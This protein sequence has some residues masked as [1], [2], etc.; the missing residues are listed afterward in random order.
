MEFTQAMDDFIMYIQ[1]EIN[2]SDNTI[3]AYM[4]DLNCYQDFLNQ[5]DRSTKLDNLTPSTSSRFVQDQ[6]LNRDIKPRTRR[7][8]FRIS[9]TNLPNP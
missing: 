3:R 7:I 1:V 6:V 8:S 9:I 5:H 4:Y 2:Y